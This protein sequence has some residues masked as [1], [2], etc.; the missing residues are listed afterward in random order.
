MAYDYTNPFGSKTPPG[1]S[2]YDYLRKQATDRSQQEGSDNMD[3][4]NRRFASMGMQN[5]GSQ[6][7]AQ[8]ENQRQTSAN[9][10]NAVGAVNVAEQGQGMQAAESQK[11]R[12]LVAHEGEAGRAIQTK[13][14]EQE[15]SQFQQ[16]LPLQK[17]ALDNQAEQMGLDREAMYF[18]ESMGQWQQ[19][20]SGGLLGGGGFLG[21]G[22]GI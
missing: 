18:N 21:S 11:Q 9:T 22:I 2:G 19:K 10:E 3:A 12:E 15:G 13:S 7:K 4:L 6:I 8:E 20:H 1:G 14:L 16:S 5:S 17:K